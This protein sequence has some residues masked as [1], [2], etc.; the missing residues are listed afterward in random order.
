MTIFYCTGC[1]AALTTALVL[2]PAVP[3][4]VPFPEPKAGESRRAPATMARG[5]YAIE[6][7]PWGA[8]YEPYPDDAEDGP[9]QRRSGS[10]SDIRGELKSAGPRNNIVIHPED[11]VDLEILVA[12]STGCC[13]GPTGDRGLNRACRCGKPVATLAADCTTVYELHLDAASVSATTED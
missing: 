12:T 4:L 6:T 3:E 5:S 13:S 1:G 8:P 10:K 7:E 2:L 9:A 11:A